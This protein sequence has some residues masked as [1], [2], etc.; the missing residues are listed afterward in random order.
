LKVQEIKNYL[1]PHYVEPLFIDS[2]NIKEYNKNKFFNSQNCSWDSFKSKVK[3]YL[4]KTKFSESH[5]T[6][7]AQEIVQLKI[8]NLEEW[9]NLTDKDLILL[10][11]GEETPNS[12]YGE[13]I[14]NFLEKRN[15]K[16]KKTW[17]HSKF[18]PNSI[19]F[20]DF[21]GQATVTFLKDTGFIESNELSV[22]ET[23]SVI[24]AEKGTV[25][26]TPSINNSGFELPK[27][28]EPKKEWIDKKKRK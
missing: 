23:Q 28:S 26:D 25:F 11:L 12:H 10:R 19:Q 15:M 6:L 9:Y 24:N 17:I 8:N 14:P 20:R 5:Y 21:Y 1:S 4:V 2:I 7:S 16:N 3:S 22:S 18:P 27:P 13:Y